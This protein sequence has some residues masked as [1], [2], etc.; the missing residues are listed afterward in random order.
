MST[1]RFLVDTAVRPLGDGRFAARLDGGW[2]IVA[3]PN[4]GYVAAVI[5]RAVEATIGDPE[6]SLRSLTLHY[7]RP[8]AEG[9][10]EVQVEVVRAGRAVST[11]AV[12]LV[13]D[14]R[15]LVVGLATAAVAV[16]GPVD[17]DE[18]AAPEVAA[19]EDVPEL[20][21][22]D[23]SP[24]PM[25]QRYRMRPCFGRPP[26]EAVDPATDPAPA[27]SGGWIRLSEPTP[28]DRVVLAALADAWWPPVFARIGA[29]ALAV[30]TV[31]LTVHFRGV[32]VDPDDWVL[33]RFESPLASGGYLVE[34]GALF[35]RHGRLLAQSRQ[36]AIL[37]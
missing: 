22:L 9:P 35:D 20:L 21:R 7:L 17:F 2:W 12:R 32:P 30:P 34:D 33:A 1:S 10:A 29:Q 14:D 28:V 4:G 16:E 37:R 6:R 24:I 36:L 5:A 19:P 3:G 26:W 15:P 31:D 23:D 13:Q 27:R 25:H 11:L 18:V 8:P